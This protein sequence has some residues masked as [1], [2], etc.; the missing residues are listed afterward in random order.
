MCDLK[1]ECIPGLGSYLLQILTGLRP[2]STANT[3]RPW[4][5]NYMQLEIRQ[6][7]IALQ[8]GV[9]KVWFLVTS[10]KSN[11]NKTCSCAAAV[12]MAGLETIIHRYIALIKER[13]APRLC[14]LFQICIYETNVHTIGV[15]YLIVCT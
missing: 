9:V 5:N 14:L 6:I 13:D 11:N 2:L 15:C 1:C 10:L 12:P 8:K 3:Y 7:R 4:A